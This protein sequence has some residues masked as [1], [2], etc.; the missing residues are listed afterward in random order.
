MP[1]F[2]AKTSELPVC[3]LCS[4]L[5]NSLTGWSEARPAELQLQRT[6][7]N[8]EEPLILQSGWLQRA[9]RIVHLSCRNHPG[10]DI[11]LL[12]GGLAGVL[13]SDICLLKH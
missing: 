13:Y 6:F 12:G 2:K 1:L 5:D 9:T 8:C 3:L 4:V 11:F 10:R 7:Y